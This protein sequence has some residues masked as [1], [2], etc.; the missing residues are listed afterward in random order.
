M[1]C[2]GTVEVD[3]VAAPKQRLERR[4]GVTPPS[5]PPTGCDDELSQ[6][7]LRTLPSICELIPVIYGGNGV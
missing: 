1:L 2:V 7:V 3:G 5:P 4:E 6:L